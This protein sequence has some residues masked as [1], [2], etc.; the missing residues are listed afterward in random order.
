MNASKSPLTRSGCVA[1]SPWDRPGDI[2]EELA[3]EPGTTTP[4]LQR[5]EASGF[6]ADAQAG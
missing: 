6:V 3:L 5:L 2:A 4:L 1:N